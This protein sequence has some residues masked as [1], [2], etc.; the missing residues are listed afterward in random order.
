M[1]GVIFIHLPAGGRF[2]ADTW[3]WVEDI[4]I[5]FGWCVIG[6]FGVAGVLCHDSS[7]H[8]VGQELVARARRLLLPWFSFSILYKV[9][10]SCLAL[11]GLIRKHAWPADSSAASILTWASTPADPQLYFLVYLFGIQAVTLAIRRLSTAL[12]VIAGIA[13]G[14][15]W[16]WM[17]AGNG[18]RPLLHGAST[19]LLPLYF[20]YF[21][22]GVGFG[23]SV[24]GL[25]LSAA[26]V[27]VL[28]GLVVL[29]IGDPTVGAQLLV[30]WLLLLV[31]RGGQATDVVKAVA[32]VGRFTGVVYVW[33]APVVV[34]V[35]AMAC[36]AVAGNGFVAVF[37]TVVA[38]FV[39]AALVGVRVNRISALRW[40]RI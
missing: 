6:F 4:Q 36:I 38:T 24:R 30:P 13:A 2:S 19:S 31:L 37:C 11:A 20:A 34:S 28:A 22:I 7:K 8:S 14:V 16:L 3:R 40:F 39:S 25:A 29:A 10:I 21:A 9:V 27:A 32:W 1:C 5:I 35:C 18:V 12:L 33:H 26:V 23:P 17:T 15:I